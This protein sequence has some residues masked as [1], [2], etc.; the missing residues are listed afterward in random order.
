M[1][2]FRIDAR[3]YAQNFI[4]IIYCVKG[5][6]NLSCISPWY[7][8]GKRS[9]ICWDQIKLEPSSELFVKIWTSWGLIWGMMSSRLRNTLPTLPASSMPT[10]LPISTNS[11]A[12]RQ[13][14]SNHCKAA[15][16]NHSKSN[17]SDPDCLFSH[18]L[19]P[20]TYYEHAA[21]IRDVVHECTKPVAPVSDVI[22]EGF[23]FK[24]RAFYVLSLVVKYFWMRH[25]SA[26]EYQCWPGKSSWNWFCHIF[27]LHQGCYFL[28]A[29]M[30]FLA[31]PVVPTKGNPARPPMLKALPRSLA[32]EAP[33]QPPYIHSF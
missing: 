11:A 1:A 13:K 2:S 30:D 22:G 19:V 31:H 7:I 18:C 24:L 28:Q 32:C 26:R 20:G 29:I 16:I 23:D 33:P 15:C 10:W 4:K 8:T 25:P 17:D 27:W 3:N 5:I 9:A 6:S 12:S 21:T 14:L